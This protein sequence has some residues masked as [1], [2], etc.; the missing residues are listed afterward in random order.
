MRPAE[1]SEDWTEMGMLQQDTASAISQC[2]RC[3]LFSPLHCFINLKFVGFAVSKH[4]ASILKAAGLLKAKNFCQA[5]SRAQGLSPEW[6]RH[7]CTAHSTS[8]TFEGTEIIESVWCA[9]CVSKKASCSIRDDLEASATKCQ[10]AKWFAQ[11]VRTG[12]NCTVSSIG[13][14]SADL[15]GFAGVQTIPLTV[16]SDP[17]LP[18]AFD[19][20]QN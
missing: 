13:Y 1:K 5:W 10:S 3:S 18:S 11:E 6:H 2:S 15:L 4:S 8:S 20:A 9:M 14:S 16:I 12:L 19:L 7:R 17:L